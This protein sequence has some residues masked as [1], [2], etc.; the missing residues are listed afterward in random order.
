MACSILFERQHIAS[1]SIFVMTHSLALSDEFSLGADNSA[2]E[3]LSDHINDTR[4]AQTHRLLAFLSHDGE[5]GFHGLCIDGTCF[6]GSIRG[7]HAAA[8]IAALESRSRR[9]G[10]AH[11]KIRIAEDNLPVGTQVDEQIELR[12]VPDHTDQSSGCDIAAHVA[13]DVGRDH[14]T[15]IRMYLN[16]QIIRIQITGLEKCRDIRFH[17]ERICIDSCKQMIHCRIGCH[18]HMINPASVQLRR[19]AHVPEHGI[20]RLLN[21]CLLQLFSAALFGG[22]DNPVD[23]IRPI[24]DL[25]VSGGC[26]GQQLSALHIQD[27]RGDSGCTN[28]NGCPTDPSVLRRKYV[29]HQHAVPALPAHCIYPESIIPKHIR[30]LLQYLIGQSDLLHTGCRLECPDQTLI[31]RHGIVQGRCFHLKLH[32][33]KIIFKHNAGFFHIF[34]C[35]IKNGDLFF[36]T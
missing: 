2:A 13:S 15:G 9:A 27:H 20:D 3:Q 30:Q 29:I 23:D 25:T 18:T 1:D 14:D 36:G 7:T 32:Y 6:N 21:D 10:A 24:T 31:I 33:R 19:T 26:L 22:F 34:F 17:T 12:F 5:G 4:S 28:V 35:S 8:D 11:H 16:P